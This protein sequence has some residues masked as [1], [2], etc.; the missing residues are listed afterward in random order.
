ML[1]ALILAVAA[2]AAD[3]K[4][5]KA[6]ISSD[7][8][9]RSKAAGPSLSVPPPAPSKPVVN[10]VLDS[11]SLGRG[12]SGPG[13]QTIHVSPGSARLEHAFP[14]PPFLALS[15]ENIRARY[16]TW[17]F[18]VL[19][20]E[21][22]VWRAEGVGRLD[23]QV[24]WDGMGADGRLAVTAG[25]SYR[26]R[27]TGR[28]GGRD[29]RIESDPVTLKSFMHREYI[30]E[31]RLEVALPEVFAAD[32]DAF[33]P[34]ADRFLNAMAESLRTSEGRR[35]GTYKLELYMREP[36]GKLA[37]ARA[38]SLAK[39]LSAALLVAVERVIVTPLPVERG[40]AVAAFLAPSKGARFRRE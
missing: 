32:K 13:T 34:G 28:R 24:D 3:S 15:P 14:E 10:E 37:K 27:F 18:E 38:R 39:K 17:A 4:S 7:I 2:C 8:T 23:D 30:G 31:T 35:D 9:V 29:F 16:D 33:A 36:R 40:E 25:Q 26:Y 19:D 1:P 21:G 22:I 12:S 11:L 5:E 6:T 20:G